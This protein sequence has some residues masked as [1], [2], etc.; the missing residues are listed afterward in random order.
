MPQLACFAEFCLD[1]DAR[2]LLRDGGPVA[3]RRKLWEC[4]CLLIEDP[5]KVVPIGDLRARLWGQVQVSDGSVN[6]LLYELRRILDDSAERPRFIETIPT[7]GIRFIAA[8]EW[9]MRE[10]DADFFVGRDAEISRLETV[11]ARVVGGERQLVVVRGEPGIGKSHLIRHFTDR[12]GARHDSPVRIHI[13]RCFAREGAAPAFL[14][15]FDILD[16]WHQ[17][18]APAKASALIGLL[19]R[20]APRWARQIPWVGGRASTNALSAAEARPERFMQE[21][22]AVFEAGST[23]QPLV[24]IFEDLHWADR[25]TVELVQY[26]ATRSTRAALL[27]LASYR[28]ADAI[29]KGHPAVRLPAAPRD[30]LTVLDLQPFARDEVRR[31]LAHVFVD[32]PDVVEHLLDDALRRSGGNPLLALALVRLAIDQNIV[33]RRG[34]RW[35]LESMRGI[36][37]VVAS[38]AVKALLEQQLA[39]LSPAQRRVVNAAAV[40]GE[41]MDAAAVAAGLGQDVEEVDTELRNLSLESSLVHEVGVS[42]WPDGTTAG[43]FR[44]RHALYRDVAYESLPAARRARLHRSIGMALEAG[45]GVAPDSVTSQLAQHF[46]AGGDHARAAD[47]LERAAVQMIARSALPEACAFYRRALDQL[48]ML[49]DDSDRAAREVRVWTGFGLATALIE[50]LESSAIQASYDAVT[51]LQSRVSDA[52]ALFPTLRTLWVFELLRFGYVAMQNLNEQMQAL[53]E[54]SGSAMYASVAASM[55]GTTHAFLG[56]L[57]CAHRCLDE[58]IASCDDAKLLPAPHAWLVDPRV[59]TRCVLAW[60]LWLRGEFARSRVTLAAAEKL[61]QESGHESTRGLTLWF[62]S[63]LAQLDGDGKGTRDAATDLKT[64]A[65]ESGL[66]AWHQIAAL[67]QALAELS[68]GEPA[69]LEDALTSMAAGDGNPTVAIAR[70][71]LLGQLAMAYSRRGKA[72]EGLA[73]VDFALARVAENGARVSEADLLRIRG[74]LLEAMGDDSGAETAYRAAIAV[75]QHQEARAFVL[76]A[77]TARVRLLRRLSDRRVATACRELRRICDSFT[78]DAHDVRIARA[79]LATM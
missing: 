72:A 42:S 18:E 11:W 37:A 41:E 65:M 71:Y 61:A 74:E 5:G 60:V 70:A 44:F 77:A 51:R 22:A 28:E 14:P 75:G 45:H 68:D 47:Y 12:I 69:A 25:A 10:S 34:V 16:A 43:R 23:A 26:L 66:P 67:T 27:V 9:R 59:E 32:S 21:I 62:R 31:C 2:V 39:T 64:L 17:S 48:S 36:A 58:S 19:R 30:R 40:A 56:D 8:V 33:S 13:G 6:T 3:I 73:L 7:R 38:S 15:V 76:R 54:A 57:G 24:L 1:R 52:N 20:H 55:A 4:L 53:A 49:T 50:G 79:T 46:E 35:Q 63:S 29:A 78:D